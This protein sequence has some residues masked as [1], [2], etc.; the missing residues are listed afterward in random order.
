MNTTA[1][2]TTSDIPALDPSVLHSPKAV[3]DWKQLH[4]DVFNTNA[5][6]VRA[7]AEAKKAIRNHA[8]RILTSE[9]FYEEALQREQEKKAKATADKL[10]EE[11]AEQ[12]KQDFLN[13][14]PDELLVSERSPASLILALEHWVRKGYSADINRIDYFDHGLYS[15]L[16][17]KS[18]KAKK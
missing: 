11:A 5:A 16:L 3:E 2:K 4:R 10:L 8:N 7:E 17:L 6:T 1:Y 12:A 13:S 15:V 9:E 18:M 14:A